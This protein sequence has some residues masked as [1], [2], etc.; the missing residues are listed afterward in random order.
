VRRY[1][2]AFAVFLVTVSVSAQT[3]LRSVSRVLPPETVNVGGVT[4]GGDEYMQRLGELAGSDD[5]RV[6]ESA[7]QALG[8]T[9]NP[10]ALPIIR[11]TQAHSDP[12]VRATAVMAVG[13]LPAPLGDEALSTALADTEA[14]VVLA[15]IRTIRATGRTELADAVQDLCQDQPPIVI[16]AAIETLTSLGQALGSETLLDVL[17]H[18]ALT[19][20]VQA[21]RHCLDPDRDRVPREV[22]TRLVQMARNDDPGVQAYALAAVGAFAFDANRDLIQKALESGHPLRALGAARAWGYAGQGQKVLQLLD[23]DLTLVEL[24]AVRAA[25]RLRLEN[26]VDKLFDR[27]K[28]PRRDLSLAAGESLIAIANDA[29]AAQASKRLL[30]LLGDPGDISQLAMMRQV[31]GL[32]EIAKAS[33]AM[34][35]VPGGTQYMASARLDAGQTGVVAELLGHLGDTSALRPILEQLRRADDLGIKQLRLSMTNP[36]AQVEYDGT[37]AASV[38]RAAGQ[39][40]GEDVLEDLKA[41]AEA[42]YRGQGLNVAVEGV[43][44]AY[45]HLSEQIGRQRSADLLLEILED[46]KFEGPGTYRAIYHLGQLKYGPAAKRIAEVAATPQQPYSIVQVAGWAHEQITGKPTPLAQPEDAPSYN[47]ILHKRR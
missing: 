24:A 14:M 22:L 28:S 17:E 45:Y 44:D 47:W 23:S 43:I 9:H 30:D 6:V 13:N 29:V 2:V 25:G 4:Y 20:R 33:R 42:E 34:Q 16:A 12:A 8:E 10:K 38:A 31:R 11:Q 19:V 27:L 37:V 1:T 40:G 36:M 35:F 26:A 15:A 21:A 18:P 7:V 32:A 39:L 41:V 5:P 46:D 3:S